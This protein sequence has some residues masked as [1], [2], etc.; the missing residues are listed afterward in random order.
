MTKK[1]LY[2]LYVFFITAACTYAQTGQAKQVGQAQ[3]QQNQYP[4]LIRLH[5]FA[6]VTFINHGQYQV[7]LNLE[8][9]N[10]DKKFPLVVEGISAKA[11]RGTTQIKPAE[12]WLQ[13]Q[14]E[15]LIMQNQKLNIIKG[16]FFVNKKPPLNHW[17]RWVQ[18]TATTNRG[19]FKSNLV[20]SPYSFN[21]TP[22]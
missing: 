21:V 8:I 14:Q 22:E 12:E 13:P 18:F 16:S 3:D 2:I 4:P 5:A 17:V 7:T 1:I 10:Q 9:H 6:D 20:A 19:R 15:F 11:W